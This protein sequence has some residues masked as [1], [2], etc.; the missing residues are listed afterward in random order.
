MPNDVKLIKEA[1]KGTNK[2]FSASAW[3]SAGHIIWIPKWPILFSMTCRLSF[4]KHAAVIDSIKKALVDSFNYKKT[5]IMMQFT[6]KINLVGPTEHHK[7][8]P[9]HKQISKN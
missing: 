6:I 5:I 1:K 8:Q 4:I 7:F 9:N 2:K 3:F